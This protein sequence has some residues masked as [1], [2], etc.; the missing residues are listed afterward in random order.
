MHDVYDSI[1]DFY[2]HRFRF[3]FKVA[4]PFSLHLHN[5]VFFRSMFGK[6]LR[7]ASCISKNTPCSNCTNANYCAYF[8]LFELPVPA[9]FPDAGK[10]KNPPRPYIIETNCPDK[11][12]FSLNETISVAITLIG[13]TVVHIDAVTSAMVHLCNI[14]LSSQKGKI[15]LEKIQTMTSGSPYLGI[16]VKEKDFSLQL[17]PFDENTETFSLTIDFATP[18]FLAINDK[19]TNDVPFRLF[20]NRVYNRIAMLNSLYCSGKKPCAHTEINPTSPISVASN[21][22]Q[23]TKI[24]PHAQFV[25]HGI[26]K[27]AYLGSLCFEG[28]LTPYVKLMKMGSYINLGKYTATGFGSYRTK[29][30]DYGKPVIC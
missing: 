21:T 25:K 9:W 29:T 14:P 13:R 27:Y 5:Y 11:K 19:A 2:I 30:L 26:Y 17:S 1:S 15:H 12:R 16:H 28:E 7:E 23:K 18:L 6:S 3:A 20:I 4:R 10:T 8:Q 24:V 22:L